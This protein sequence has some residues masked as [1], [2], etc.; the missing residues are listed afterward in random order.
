[1]ILGLHNAEPY[2]ISPEDWTR[3][4]Y[5]VGATRSGKTTLLLNL[6]AQAIEQGD[7]LCF[8]DP[9]GDAADELLALIPRHRAN[10]LIL[11]DLGYLE[12]A[13]PWNPL[14]GVKPD[15]HARVAD[16]VVSAMRH[17][18]RESWG[19][20]MQWI[21]TNLVR[22]ELVSHGSLWGV[23]TGST[24]DS[25]L[26]RRVRKSR[27]PSVRA[28]WDVWSAWDD[29]RRDEAMSPVINKLG[30][31]FGSDAIRNVLG[32]DR[33]KLDI[34]PLD[35]RQAMDNKAIII[36]KLA[37]GRIG[38]ENAHLFGALLVAGIV[39]AA[40]SRADIPREQR[41]PFNLFVDEFQSFAST[42]FDTGLS[43]GA[44]YGLTI[45][46]ANQ[47]TAQLDER[48][49]SSIFGN[50]GN[51]VSFR[52]GSEDAKALAGQFGLHNPVQAADFTATDNPLHDFCEKG[53]HSSMP[54][55]QQPNYHAWARV[56]R[57]GNPEMLQLQTLPPPPPVNPRVERMVEHNRKKYGTRR[58]LVEASLATVAHP[59]KRRVR[60]W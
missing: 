57:G 54:L 56:L 50:V 43:E 25:Y 34:N 5:C 6:M 17:V 11:I 8:L 26:A 44:K 27:D 16:D 4:N 60:E 13:V 30:A 40:L 3:H 32:Q 36:V 31:L 19:P 24:N 21:L 45:C 23:F 20:R 33:S 46:A 39:S 7:G 51:L 22:V 9:H 38:E 49:R 1:M 28:F 58:E 35:L 47:F 53:F 12:R 42:V 29:R 48:L 41:V 52:V 37:K 18:W 15:D 59:R 55:V 2:G 14:Y 10:D